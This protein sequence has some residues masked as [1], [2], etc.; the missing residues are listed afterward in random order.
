MAKFQNR[1]KVLRKLAAI[2][3]AVRSAAKQ[4]LAQSADELTEAIRTAAP[5][6]A[7]GELKKSIAQTWGGGAV[8]YSSLRG[9]VGQAGDPDLSVVISAGNSKVRYSHLVEFGT[10]PHI[11]GGLFAGTEH[12]GTRAQP[13]FYP[14]YRKLRRRARSRISRAITKA[15]KQ[16]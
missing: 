11:N 13:F 12:P 10:A 9:N 1:E 4:A 8:R 7:T 15:I 6:G 16:L 5:R 14:T 3:Q 2:P